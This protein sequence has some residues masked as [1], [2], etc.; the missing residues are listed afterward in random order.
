MSFF[1]KSYLY[2]GADPGFFVG[3]SPPLRRGITD[4]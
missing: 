2:V 4:W 3:W 1:Y